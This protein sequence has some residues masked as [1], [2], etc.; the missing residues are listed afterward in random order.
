MS[1]MTTMQHFNGLTAD[2]DERLALL[3]EECA[4][5]IQ[6]CTKIQRHGYESNNKGQ[7][8]ETNRQALERELGDL[9]HC[10]HRMNAAEDIND[11]RIK[12]LV[13][14]PKPGINAYLHHNGS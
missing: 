13:A 8:P 1:D 12:S 6:C 2:Q 11:K 7:L 9:I 4:E 5:V 10:Y 14:N 3:I